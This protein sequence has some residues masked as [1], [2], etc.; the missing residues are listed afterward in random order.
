[1]RKSECLAAAE[2][3]KLF[4]YRRARQGG[5]RAWRGH[6]KAGAPKDPGLVVGMPCDRLVGVD[7]ELF[8]RI[9]AHAHQLVELV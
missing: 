4:G 5:C 8:L 6:E 1:M 3:P 2:N 7:T 9:G